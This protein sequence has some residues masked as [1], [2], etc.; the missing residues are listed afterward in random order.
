MKTRRVINSLD[1]ELLEALADA[2]D[3]LAIADAFAATQAEAAVSRRRRQWVH[4]LG[5]LAAAVCLVAALIM[6]EPGSEQADSFLQR[7]RAAV[8]S[9]RVIH[10]VARTESP[11]VRVLDLQTGRS[12]PRSVERELWFDRLTGRIHGVTRSAGTLIQDFVSNRN[13]VGSRAPRIESV[14]SLGPALTEFVVG[15]REAIL[16]GRFK[17][18]GHGVVP[19]VDVVVLE[20][21]VRGTNR[22]RVAVN[23]ATGQPT[24]FWDVTPDGNRDSSVWRVV[25]IAWVAF[26]SRNFHARRSLPAT[27]SGEVVGVRLISRRNAPRVLLHPLWC[28][29]KVLDLRLRGIDLE[30]LTARAPSGARTHT[31]GLALFYANSGRPVLPPLARTS[32]TVLEA[33]SPQPAYRFGAGGT[34]FEGYPVP[35][36]GSVEVAPLA[37]PGPGTPWLGQLRQGRWYVTILASTRSAIVA[38]ARALRPL[39]PGADAEHPGR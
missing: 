38:A 22:E 35:P 2:P 13:S 34:T 17:I 15:Y 37:P 23:P 33:R 20:F 26:D 25:S 28:G 11:F 4:R 19:G 5:A 29:P 39:P 30:S 27:S 8:G 12:A 6:L 36:A 7:A 3:L 10:L 21:R 32:L 31:H 9:E 24:S 16:S 14:A 1:R 18:V